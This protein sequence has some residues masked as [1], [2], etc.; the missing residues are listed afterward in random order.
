MLINRTSAAW[1]LSGA[2][3]APALA[4]ADVWVFEPSAALDQRVDDNYTID[5]EMPDPVNATRI[6]GSLGLSRESQNTA[7]K[8]LI[9]VDG[10]LQQSENESSELSS[11]Q[12]LYLD[13]KVSSERTVYGIGI[14]FKQ[15]TP[16]RD[17]SADITDLSVT[18]ADT[19]ASVSQDQ[20]VGR[21]RLVISP[22][23]SYKL[24]R[25]TSVNTQLAYTKVNHEL[26]SVEDA[27]FAQ[28][29]NAE[30]VAE[31][32]TSTD[33]VFL[34][35]DELDNFKETAFT[36]GMKHS[37]S[38]LLD[39][40]ASI[41]FKDYRTEIELDKNIVLLP[42][43]DELIDSRER[44]IHR[45]PK[46]TSKSTTTTINIGFERS[47]S[48]TLKVGFSV[49]AYANTK[50]DTDLIRADDVIVGSEEAVVA[51]RADATATENGWLGGI[52]LTKT[53]GVTRYT[54]RF[55]VDVLPSDIGS[56]VESLDL[57]GDMVREISPRMDFALRA[58]AYEPDAINAT[59][60]DEFSRRFISFEPKIIWQYSR[61]WTLA[62]SYRYRRQKSRADANSGESNAFLIS[63]KYTPPS[64]IRD[65]ERGGQ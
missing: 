41:S 55:G 63:L 30:E 19:G 56:Q 37:W 62:G 4:V 58:R 6:V 10:L 39:L 16:S 38:P 22:N 51:A 17:I 31:F 47:L 59:G 43:E 54:G 64:A 23:W 24:S 50:D 13:S 48:E 45:K 60:V 14:N 61:A 11:N 20:N 7:F 32:L 1:M 36:I 5:T 65:A 46:R 53:T 3:L 35:E 29:G 25:R 52:T 42:F 27:A 9:R 49:G 15:D 34:V 44:R 40:N 2:L 12:I 21:Q 57:V 28:F 8:G 33:Q 18:A 26:P